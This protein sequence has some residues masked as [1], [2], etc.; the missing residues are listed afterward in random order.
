MMGLNMEI[1]YTAYISWK[2]IQCV[3]DKNIRY[4]ANDI[5]A[6]VSQCRARKRWLCLVL[7]SELI[8]GLY[9]ANERRRDYVTP[10]LIG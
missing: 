7:N 1:K 8:L 6:H 2:M 4:H 3:W 9:P 10:S 5:P